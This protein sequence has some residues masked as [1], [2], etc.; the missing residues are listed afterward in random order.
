MATATF[1]LEHELSDFLL[2][3]RRGREFSVAQLDQLLRDEDRIA[4]SPNS[5]LSDAAHQNY[6]GTSSPVRQIPR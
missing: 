1:R 6:L 4:V 2:P 5:G 3:G